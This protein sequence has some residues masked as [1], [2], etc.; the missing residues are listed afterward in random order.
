MKIEKLYIEN[1]RSIKKQN[2]ED[3]R[4]A[5][6]LIGKNNSG[7]SAIINAVRAFWGDIGLE[8]G[9]FYKNSKNIIIEA[10]F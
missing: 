1:F 3:I 10:T 7:K 6:I 5:L 8:K 4:D 9:D 2:I